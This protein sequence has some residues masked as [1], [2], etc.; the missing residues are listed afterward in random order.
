MNDNMRETPSPE[1]KRLLYSVGGIALTAY[2]FRRRG[3]VGIA[4]GAA[5]AHFLR[6]GFGQIRQ[7]NP[8]KR[9]E[10]PAIAASP[11]KV[12]GDS[13][14]T[15]KGNP[16]EIYAFW[17]NV[18]NAPHFVSFVTSVREMS[19]NVSLW[20]FQYGNRPALEVI[21]EITQDTPGELIGWNLVGSPLVKGEG[22]VRFGPASLNGYTEVRLEQWV[23]PVLPVLR[24]I[25]SMLLNRHVAQNLRNFKQ[26]FET[27][28]I[29]TTRGQPSGKRS[30]FVETAHK[31]MAPLNREPAR[32][33]SVGASA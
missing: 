16:H 26:L 32:Q 13:T 24:S 9:T 1:L 28:E 27:G 21:S 10:S 19:P 4:C 14:I 31:I 15:V 30:V 8:Q 5:G 29:A 25:S 12:V 23:T 7:G 33:K 6:Q 20:K 11:A 17:R 22:I 2:A 3:V 18:K